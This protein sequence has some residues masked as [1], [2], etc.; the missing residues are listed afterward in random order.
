MALL[1]AIAAGVPAAVTDVGGN[2]EVVVNGLTGW[3]VAS[4]SV[5]DL[6]N[7][8][9]EAASNPGKAIQFSDSGRRRFNEKFT[10]EKM[11]Q[12]YNSIYKEMLR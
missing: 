11:L 10:L 4:D 3:V 9:L 8:I 6:K 1:E 7:A 2:P 5:Q 12:N